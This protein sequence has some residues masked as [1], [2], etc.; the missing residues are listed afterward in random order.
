[1][2]KFGEMVG[3]WDEDVA[4][5]KTWLEGMRTLRAGDINLLFQGFH[6]HIIAEALSQIAEDWQ[7][8]GDLWSEESEA[9][10]QESTDK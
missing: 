9:D 3:D 1:M 7:E 8:F 6:P 10:E 5:V 2:K 4:E